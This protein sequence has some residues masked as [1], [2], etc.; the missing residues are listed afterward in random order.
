MPL[1]ERGSGNSSLLS[2]QYHTNPVALS[3]EE[4]CERGCSPAS[5][6]E[7]L[8]LCS[9][10]ESNIGVEDDHNIGNPLRLRLVG[11][12]P[13]VPR[14]SFPVNPL[15][16]I[17]S[18]VTPHTVKLCSRAKGPGRNCPRP[19]TEMTRSQFCA[20]DPLGPGHYRQHL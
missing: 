4:A 10:V 12:Q 19:R 13:P 2:L 5:A 11:D 1:P 20:P 16:I 15:R 17:P 8:R 7:Q 18:N 3:E 9:L 14:G 6:L